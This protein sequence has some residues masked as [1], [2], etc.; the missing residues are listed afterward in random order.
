MKQTLFCALFFMFSCFA[1]NP[2]IVILPR[3]AVHDGDFF[4]FG[5]SVEI[6]GHVKGDVYVFGAQVVID[7]TVEG[8]VLASAGSIALTGSVERSV[9]AVA[10]QMLISGKIG[11]AL[12]CIA[13]NAQ[14]LPSGGVRESV[15]ALAGN[16]DLAGPIG[17][18][19]RTYASNVRIAGPI[20]QNFYGFVGRLHV[21][22]SARVKGRVDYWSDDPAVISPYAQITFVKRH[23]TSF[24]HGVFDSVFAGMLKLSARY[25]PLIMN[26]FYSFI[27][28]LVIMRFFPRKVHGA[29]R[30]LSERP[31]QVLAAGTVVIL[32]LPI[33]FAALL[34][35]I[36]G[37]PFALTLLA[38][39]IIGLYTVKVVMILFVISK[40]FPKSFEKR[41]RGYLFC[42]LV[43]YFG[44]TAIPYVGTVISIVF[45]L[46][47]LGALIT[48]KQSLL[49]SADDL[50][51]HNEKKAPKKR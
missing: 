33:I 17:K 15:V 43:V 40:L 28:G 13:G 48:G 32:F 1:S 47:G 31:L 51:D 49:W 22:S 38:I 3:G 10:G 8:D 16:V 4:A 36:V 30:A 35:S 18:N 50:I 26:F 2:S 11:G 6:S 39:N 25:M 41:R 5:K 9:R 14:L 44:V 27:I 7:G 21:T 46:M 42:G 37:A 29:M 45:I 23:S 34:I 19:A 12:T 24:W 20:A